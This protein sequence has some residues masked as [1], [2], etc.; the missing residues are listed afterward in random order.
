[1]FSAPSK[2]KQLFSSYSSQNIKV[3]QNNLQQ[4]ME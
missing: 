1:M 2:L 4:M 3:E